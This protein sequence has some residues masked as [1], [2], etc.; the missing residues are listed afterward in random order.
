M[1]SMSFTVDEPHMKCTSVIVYYSK[2]KPIAFTPVVEGNTKPEVPVEFSGLKFAKTSF[3]RAYVRFAQIRERWNSDGTPR[4]LK[5]RTAVKTDRRA[6]PS[7]PPAAKS[8]DATKR[9]DV[10]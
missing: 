9:S 4:V 7:L 1:N 6:A 8:R 5:T 3:A 2:G 10:K